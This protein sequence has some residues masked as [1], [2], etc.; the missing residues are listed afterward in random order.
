MSISNAA[1]VATADLNA[2]TTTAQTNVLADTTDVPLG[3]EVNLQWR[4][5]VAGT[6][7]ERRKAIVVVPFDCYLETLA[8]MTGDMTNPSTVTVTVTGDGALANWPVSVS[9]AVGASPANMARLLYDNTKTKAD[10]DFSTTA[11]AFRVYPAGT[12]VTVQCTSNSAATPN[13][14]QAVLVFREFWSRE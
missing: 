13:L 3:F 12:T 11:R 4:D 14:L 7:S 6:S 8:V 1:T 10:I 2:M 5:I 9:A